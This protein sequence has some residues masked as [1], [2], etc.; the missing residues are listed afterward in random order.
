M[1]SIGEKAEHVRQA[2]RE[3]DAGGHECHWPGC[4]K[5]V[6]PAAWGCL[7]HWRLL[8]ASIRRAIWA[9]YRVGQEQ[10][11]TPSKDYVSAAQR[12]QIWIRDHHAIVARTLL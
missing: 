7:R 1:T 8:P 4:G 3:G 6:P 5:A 12:A 10:T 2:L 9:E 11:K